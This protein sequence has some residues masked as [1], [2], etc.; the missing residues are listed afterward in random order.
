MSWPGARP[1]QQG[2]ARAAPFPRDRGQEPLVLDRGRAGRPRPPSRPT[3]EGLRRPVQTEEPAPAKKGRRQGSP[4]GAPEALGRPRRGRPE[5]RARSVP[6]PPAGGS[7]STP[8]APLVG[9]PA[10]PPVKAVGLLVGL[11]CCR[12]HRPRRRRPRPGLGPGRPSAARPGRPTECP[13]R[14]HPSRRCRLGGQPARTAPPRAPSRPSRPGRAAARGPLRRRCSAAAA[15][16]TGSPAGDLPRHLGTGRRHR[17]RPGRSARGPPRPGC[18]SAVRPRP[19]PPRIASAPAAR[20][21]ALRAGPCRRP[22]GRGHPRPERT[23]DSA[24]AGHGRGAPSAARP[25]SAA[26]RGAPA[27]PGPAAVPP[28]AGRPSGGARRPVG[29]G[30]GG[31]PSVAASAAGSG[32]GAPRC[33]ARQGGRGG[34][35]AGARRNAGHAGAGATSRSSSRP[36]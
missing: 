32:A 8:P 21:S 3:P 18:P 20:R 25:S 9:C 13:S 16:L 19:D 36:S 12:V 24:P 30:F 4:T 23:A 5:E 2:R 17:R 33:A 1:H 34:S 29:G 35:R 6:G 15:A 22:R 10:R 7:R 31:R 28:A 27:R 14:S 26:T 11:G